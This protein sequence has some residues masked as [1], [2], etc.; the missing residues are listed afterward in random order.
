[1]NVGVLLCKWNEL[2][3]Y[4][5]IYI[6]VQYDFVNV[7]WLANNQQSPTTIPSA[8]PLLLS[9]LGSPDHASSDPVAIFQE[10]DQTNIDVLMKKWRRCSCILYYFIVLLVP[11]QL[12]TR[13]I[14]KCFIMFANWSEEII[15]L[16]VLIWS[17]GQICRLFTGFRLSFVFVF[18]II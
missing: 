1:M 6:F 15:I 13:I 4:W 7:G 18:V 12:R 5:L 17:P 3:T 10:V 14:F 8:A 16:I 9:N 2:L 11:F